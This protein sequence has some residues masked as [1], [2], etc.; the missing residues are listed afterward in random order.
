MVY[1]LGIN[2]ESIKRIINP[3]RLT[4]SQVMRAVQ[5]DRDHLDEKNNWYV[6]ANVL[7]YFK[8]RKDCRLLG[9]LLNKEI[10]A[11]F[12]RPT[13]DYQLVR[14][15]LGKK[16]EVEKIGLLS[17]NIQKPDCEYYDMSNL[18]R[19]YPEMTRK[20]G[21]YTIK[22]LLEVLETNEVPGYQLLQQDI[23]TTYI[24]DWFCHQLD[25]NPK[26]LLFER[27]ENGSLTLSTLIDNE[28][29]FGINNNGKID[30]E[31]PRLWLPA[32]PYS[33]ADFASNPIDFEGCDYNIVTLLLDYPEYVI[34][35][36][37]QL[38]DSNFDA[39]INQYRNTLNSK[40]YLPE[41]GI[42]FLRNFVYEKQTESDK[43]LRL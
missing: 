2:K 3:V 26:N 1:T 34:P 17:P 14:F 39:V 8:A 30:T 37:K 36:L 31:Y 38:T 15:A 42:S 22:K 23:I 16:G 28:S 32:I 5:I 41:E 11:N 9:E 24:L 4:K 13:A 10:Y 12:H 33:E 27:N 21:Q 18:H 35:L 25:R 6:V 20:Y 43:I 29:S 7:S 40:I 19:L